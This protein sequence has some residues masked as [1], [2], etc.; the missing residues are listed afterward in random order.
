VL[1]QFVAYYMDNVASLADEVG[2]I[3]LSEV[4]YEHERSKLGRA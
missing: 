2:F 1:Q 4:S 3:P